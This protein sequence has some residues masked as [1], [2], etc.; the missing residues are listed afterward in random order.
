MTIPALR[1]LNYNGYGKPAGYNLMK[2]A[3]GF[4][5]PFWSPRQIAPAGT[6]ARL[7]IFFSDPTAANYDGETITL[8]QIVSPGTSANKVFTFDDDT[9]PPSTATAVNIQGLGTNALIA[10]QF[11][12]AAGLAGFRVS[13]PG[14][15]VVWVFQPTPGSVGNTAVL[16][17]ANIDSLIEIN[18]ESPVDF[19][20]RFFSGASLT[21]PTRVGPRYG[22]GFDTFETIQNGST[23]IPD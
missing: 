1:I 3:A 4:E 5:M 13:E 17:S 20:T 10:A 19:T 16:L 14:G 8:T 11:A 9:P 12:L 22:M 18:N 15:A 7:K 2:D 21:I 6:I 23:P